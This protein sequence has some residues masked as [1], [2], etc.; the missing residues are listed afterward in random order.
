M[1]LSEIVKFNKYAHQRVKDENKK[2]NESHPGFKIGYNYYTSTD[3]PGIR[4]WITHQ[5]LQTPYEIY[6]G[7]VDTLSEGKTKIDI[8][9]TRAI[10]KI[11]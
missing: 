2:L 1:K 4:F 3:K 7:T 8:A 5:S 9:L 11:K 10:S 6:T